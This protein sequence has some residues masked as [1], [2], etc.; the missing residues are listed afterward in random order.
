MASP[1]TRSYHGCDKDSDGSKRGKLSVLIVDEN[2]LVCRVHEMLVS[3]LKV[4]KELLT[5][6]ATDG[7]E[8]L[9]LH[10]SG[11]S[12]D[13]ILMEMD[14]P[15]MDGPEVTKKLRAMGVK[16]IIVGVTS[17][18]SKV[19]REAFMAAGLDVWLEKPLTAHKLKSV[20]EALEKK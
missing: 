20:V 9:D 4:A 15:I 17:R 2:V 14:L 19:D 6:T 1:S 5:E 16:S 10:L 18:D 11:S 13:V 12:F 8:A 7:K 3:K